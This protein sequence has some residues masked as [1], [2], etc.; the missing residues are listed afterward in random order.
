MAERF[1]D[2]YR[3]GKPDACWP[4][5][6]TIHHRG[7][8][9]IVNDHKRNALAHRVTYERFNGPIPDG[10]MVCHRCDNPPCVNPAHLFLGTHQDNMT[11]RNRKGRTQHGER[12]HHA[13]LTAADVLTIRSLYP[14]MSQ[15]AIA[16]QFGI[17]QT[18]VSDIVRRIIWK[19]V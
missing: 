5:G 7:Y 6:G 17:N 15:T 16:K 9:I 11:D 3:P 10:M 19:H 13:K 8:G 18:I 2:F 1:L 12:H 14:G 4:W